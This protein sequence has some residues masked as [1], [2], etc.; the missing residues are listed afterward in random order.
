MI[1][2][3]EI[4][5]ELVLLGERIIDSQPACG[6]GFIRLEGMEQGNIDFLNGAVYDAVFDEEG[7]GW[8]WR[9]LFG[10]V[11]PGQYVGRIN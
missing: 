8:E 6:L 11:V 1:R 3:G 9:Y 4:N 7:I 10:G 5:G 2:F